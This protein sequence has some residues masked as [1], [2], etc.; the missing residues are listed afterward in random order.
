MLQFAGALDPR[1]WALV[2]EAERVARPHVWNP[3]WSPDP[4]L[5][6]A[7]RRRVA[8]L[9]GPSR[10]RVKGDD[11]PARAM[12]FEPEVHDVVM[13]R[14]VAGVYFGCLRTPAKPRPQVAAAAA[15]A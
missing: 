13:T 1:V 8:E 7:F 14:V 15:V 12:L 10:V 2:I 5:V 6:A 4:I 3:H 11:H 9:V